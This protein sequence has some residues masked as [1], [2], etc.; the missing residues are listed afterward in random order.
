MGAFMSNLA[1]FEVPVEDFGR[2]KKFY[3]SLLGWKF[4][5]DP[6]MSAAMEYWDI[7]TGEPKEGTI[8]MGGMYKRQMPGSQIVTY[9]IV[10]DVDAALAKVEKLGGK[11]L[12][13]K[14]V[15][16]TV[17]D[18]ATI[19]DSEGNAIGIWKPVKK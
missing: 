11:I 13:P 1:Y 5:K 8:A 7:T 4:E 2:A 17:G 16:E 12:M 10:E 6:M 15:V 14:M 18:V 19:Q 3:Q 9:A